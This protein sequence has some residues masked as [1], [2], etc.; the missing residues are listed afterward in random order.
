MKKKTRSQRPRPSSASAESASPAASSPSSKTFLSMLV[1]C[2]EDSTTDETQQ[3]RTEARE[4]LHDVTGSPT[5][6]ASHRPSRHHAFRSPETHSG[7]HWLNSGAPFLTSTT[8]S[9]TLRKHPAASQ[10][11]AAHPVD[12]DMEEAEALD[13]EI[14]GR[15]ARK[16]MA[17]FAQR[18]ATLEGGTDAEDDDD[19]AMPVRVKLHSVR[20]RGPAQVRPEA[21]QPLISKL[22]AALGKAPKLPLPQLM[23]TVRRSRGALLRIQHWLNKRNALGPKKLRLMETVSLGEKRFVA[24]IEVDGQRLLIG[25]GASGV[26]LLRSLENVPAAGDHNLSLITLGSGL[27]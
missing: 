13:E 17:A 16:L 19:L 27:A 20:E 25:G 9:W 5:D 6:D 2:A 4:A 8:C 11:K 21:K 7:S 24:V 15:A 3:A 26:S 1:D 10:A 18:T 23:T 12:Y 22:R 14:P